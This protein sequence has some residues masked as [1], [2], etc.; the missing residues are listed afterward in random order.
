MHSELLHNQ[1]FGKA[2]GFTSAFV[3]AP[4]SN[5]VLAILVI[6]GIAL[7]HCFD[8]WAAKQISPTAKVPNSAKSDSGI[9]PLGPHHHFLFTALGHVAKNSGTVTR[10]HIAS[11][12]ATMRAMKFSSTQ[13]NEA[14]AAFNAGK[15]T[16]FNFTKLTSSFT[17]DDALRTFIL[18]SICNIAAISPQDKAL[19]AAVRLAGYLNISPAQVAATFGEALENRK[20]AHTQTNQSS[21]VHATTESNKIDE[22][23]FKVLGIPL[24]SS[25]ADAKK[26]YRKLISKAHPDKLPPTA[27]EKEILAATQRMVEL[28]EALEAIQQK[29]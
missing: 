14:I 18:H 15:S 25:P 26:A 5:T 23:P 27:N 6:V 8:W 1:W 2:L 3:L 22:G 9:S 7:G 24:G 16:S 20:T 10:A 21:K 11:A 17:P 13:R 29:R 12:E 28:R 19:A 4:P